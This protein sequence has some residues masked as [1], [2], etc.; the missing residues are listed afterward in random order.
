MKIPDSL[1]EG[2]L[3]KA[4]K[5]TPDQLKDLRAEEK[6]TGTSLQDLVIKH[7]FMSDKEL[8]ALST[9]KEKPVGK[10]QFDSAL[11]E[12]VVTLLLEYAVRA[13]ASSIHIEPRETH[14]QVRY[15]IDG[16][17][18]QANKLPRAILESLVSHLKLQG[19]LPADEFRVPQEARFAVTLAHKPYTVR[20]ST[21]PIADGEKVVLQLLDESSKTLNLE[22]LGL[23]GP[24]LKQLRDAIANPQ[25]L[26]LIAGP[27]DAGTSTTLYSTLSL[28]D[29]PTLNISTI[30]NPV[31]Y[32]LPGVNQTQV[33]PRAGISF[34]NGLRALLGQDPNVIMVGEL[35]DTETARLAV[36]A[37]LRGHLLFSVVH[38][39]NAAAAVTR[40]VAMGIEPFL[41]AS[42]LRAVVGQRLVRRLCEHCRVEYKP[43]SHQIE[44]LSNMFGI[45]DKSQLTKLHQLEELAAKEG[46]GKDIGNTF[47]ITSNKVTRLWKAH[48]TGC[49]ACGHSGYKGRIGIFE[50]LPTSEAIQ[51][52]IIGQASTTAI[53]SQAI[54]DGMIPM[55]IDGFIKVLR[56]QTSVEEVLRVTS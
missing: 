22:Q 1:L 54:R 34:A 49:D 36:Q 29:S 46:V 56:A 53:Q 14:V 38:T 30:E 51:K 9:T 21:L 50:T 45:T 15:R 44:D 4:G 19:N 12:R 26:V 43:A 2:L 13:G 48:P 52:L 24:N 33:S 40:L 32:R 55:Y 17:L 23:W 41:V 25:G 3:K 27:A 8:V 37:S 35:G 16:L 6:K 20:V 39:S 11:L 47:G 18:R 10:K 7:K 5:L 28:L 42:T 31:R